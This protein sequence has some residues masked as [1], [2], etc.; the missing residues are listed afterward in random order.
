MRG[1]AVVVLPELIDQP[2][3]V[4]S[5]QDIGRNA[6]VR[7]DSLSKANLVD[8]IGSNQSQLHGLPVLRKLSHHLGPREVPVLTVL[9]VDVVLD[10]QSRIG[11]ELSQ[12]ASDR[13]STRLNYSHIP[14]SRMPSSA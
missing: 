9:E 12:P 13:K 3:R 4:F 5:F 7:G 8:L 11:V 14:L 1:H 10:E 6:P 2:L